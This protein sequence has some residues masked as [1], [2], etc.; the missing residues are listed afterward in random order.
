MLPKKLI[1]L[2]LQKGFK[3]SLTLQGRLKN[4]ITWAPIKENIDIDLNSSYKL[5][6]LKLYL[7]LNALNKF[8]Y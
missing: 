2:S 1:L 7:L 3:N 5:I 8:F 6:E 4:I